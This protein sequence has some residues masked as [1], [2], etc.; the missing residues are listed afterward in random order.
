MSLTIV[1]NYRGFEI[2]FSTDNERFSFSFD[3][4]SWHEKQSY[5]ACKT[6][7][8]SFLKDNANFK[9]FKIRDKNSGT[10]HDVIGIRKDEKFIFINYKGEKDQLPEYN[11]NSYVIFDES[12]DVVYG[13]IA[14]IESE[15]DDLKQR[16]KDEKS[17]IQRPTLKEIKKQYLRK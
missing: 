17:K 15:I 13:R 7:I 9:P 1:D 12:D 14:I 4:G 3:E 16:I 5:A 8:D 6:K 2:N 10:V 11:E